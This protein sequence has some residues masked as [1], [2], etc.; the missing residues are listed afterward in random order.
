MASFAS[1]TIL[2][3]ILFRFGILSFFVF[4]HLL[5]ASIANVLS[6]ELSHVVFL[7]SVAFGATSHIHFIDF[8]VGYSFT[9]IF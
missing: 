1:F 4:L 5:V 8:T 9:Q 6:L 3:G 7:A 2:F